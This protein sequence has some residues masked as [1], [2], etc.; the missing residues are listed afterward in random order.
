MRLSLFASSGVTKLGKTHLSVSLFCAGSPGKADVDA[1]LQSGA[2]DLIAKRI[3]ATSVATCVR[4]LCDKRKPSIAAKDHIDPIR[5][6]MSTD[7]SSAEKFEPPH[8]RKA[9]AI[10][11]RLDSAAL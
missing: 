4:L 11:T 10:G 3:P 1:A 2:D 6:E 5:A 7:L 9:K 8:T